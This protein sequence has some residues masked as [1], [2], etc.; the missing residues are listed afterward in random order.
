MHV[1]RNAM[2]HGIEGTEE[3]QAKGKPEQG[4]ITLTTEVGT[5]AAVL[6]VRD[7]GRGIAVGK[8]YEMAVEK[9]I[10]SADDAKPEA[11]EIANLIFS[12]GFS[13]AEEV[14]DV[15]GRGVGMDAV[16]GFLEDQGGSIEIVLDDG[17]D[18]DDFRTFTTKI[19]LP[20]KFYTVALDFAQSA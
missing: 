4:S 14:T 12:S 6:S 2:D 5:D 13:T 9:G 1:F 18:T 11:K 7:D 19:V 10:Y 17:S 16:K 20:A 3:R 8:I 15:S